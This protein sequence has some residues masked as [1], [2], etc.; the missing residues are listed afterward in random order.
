MHWEYKTGALQRTGVYIISCEK[1]YTR[2]LTIIYGHG[3]KFKF[4]HRQSFL[5][6]TN[7]ICK[8]HGENEINQDGRNTP[9]QFP[10]R[11]CHSVTL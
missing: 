7:H 11:L 6:M 5:K 2:F 8:V 9:I 10:K 1:N 4:I 3:R